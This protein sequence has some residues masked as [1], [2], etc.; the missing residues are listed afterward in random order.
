VANTV[1]TL[2]VCYPYEGC[3]LRGV[4]SSK[5]AAE[6]WFRAHQEDYPEYSAWVIDE[7][8]VVIEGNN[9]P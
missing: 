3:Q 5:H 9:I 1:W 4:F 6:E 7:P 2:E 8:E